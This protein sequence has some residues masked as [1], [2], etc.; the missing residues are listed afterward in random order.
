MRHKEGGPSM[1]LSTLPKAA[2]SVLGGSRDRFPSD[3]S[4]VR[5]FRPYSFD[6]VEIPWID[7][8][9]EC[10]AESSVVFTTTKK[11]MLSLEGVLHLFDIS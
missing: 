8:G 5:F 3:I 1:S 4:M 11:V 6:P 10:I 2:T 7:F 9:G